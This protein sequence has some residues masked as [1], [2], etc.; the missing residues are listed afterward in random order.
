MK[1]RRL[2]LGCAGIIAA[3]ACSHGGGGGSA[4]L[5]LRPVLW[6]SGAINFG[7]VEAVVETGNIAVIFGAAGAS[8]LSG[9][10]L[11]AQDGS[12]TGWKDAAL[13][14]GPDGLGSWIV[15]IGTDGHVY[16][17]KALASLEDVSGVFGVSTA[18]VVAIA[19][20]GGNAIGFATATDLIIANGTTVATYA[21]AAGG[22]IAGGGG[23]AASVVGD[24]V[25]VFDVASGVLATYPLAGAKV[26]GFDE[27]GHLAV[28]ANESLWVEDAGGILRPRMKG[29]API[30]GLTL[31][32]TSL[33]FAAGGELG[34][35]G[36]GSTHGASLRATSHLAPSP[37]GEVWVLGDLTLAKFAV[38]DGSSGAET[39][40]QTDIAPIFDQTCSQCHLPGGSAGTDLSSYESWITH[41]DLIYQRVVVTKDMP[42]PGTAFS[43][44]ERDIIAAW[45][46]TSAALAP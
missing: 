39:K 6:N 40:W 1:A 12:V 36:S 20:L 28:G 43:Q 33:W 5:A 16:R 27:T 7:A 14:P 4:T 35:L 24:T 18:G 34:M 41:H 21:G 19:P 31:S 42:P 2:A 30:H 22:N 46:T 17:V 23:R 38:D 32:G 45:L 3:A 10:S 8:V 13:I 11:L 29:A 15:G 26:A 9:G 44:S 25:N 37:S